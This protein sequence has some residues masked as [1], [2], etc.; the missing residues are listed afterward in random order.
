MDFLGP[1][2]TEEKVKG[3]KRNRDTGKTIKTNYIFSQ[4]DPI[5]CP[6]AI[7]PF[8]FFPHGFSDA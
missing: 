3:G 5:R 1:R 8:I 7:L 4:R 6:T 2:A